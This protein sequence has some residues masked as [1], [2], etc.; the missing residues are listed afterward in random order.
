MYHNS[1]TSKRLLTRLIVLLVILVCSQYILTGVYIGKEMIS[2][3][4]AATETEN[5]QSSEE[6]PNEGEYLRLSNVLTENSIP[7]RRE[8]SAGWGT[9]RV[10]QDTNGNK[11]SVKMEGAYY[12]FD[13]GI[14]AHASSNLYYDISEYSEKYPY[15]TLYMGINQTSSSGN[16]VKVWIYT[17]NNDRFVSSGSQ[18]WTQKNAEADTNRVIMP[19]QNA[20]FEKV[21]IRGAKY[22]RIQAYDNGSNASDHI[23]YINPM[24][25]TE[26]YEE[27]KNDF[28]GV[29]EYDREIK[30]YPNKTL[31]DPK[32]E[33][34]VLQ[35]EFVN[36]VGGY[37]LNRFMTEDPENKMII[38]WLMNDVENL[39][40]YLLGGKPEGNQYLNSFKIL[41]R[42]Y[43][44]RGEDLNDTTEITTNRGKS[45]L[46]KMYKTMMLAISLT[47]CNKVYLW[48]NGG[49]VSDPV[50][51]YDIY[52][53][54]YHGK[55]EANENTTKGIGQ[56]LI[57]KT[58]FASLTVEEMRW[59]MNT[60]IDNEEI[61][62]LNWYAREKKNGA[63]GPY[64]YQAYT[65]GYSY[66]RAKYYDPANYDSW[67]AK[68]N[69][70]SYNITYKAGNPKLWIVFEEGSVCGGLSKTG[71][72]V[73]GSFKG[74]PNTCVSQPGHCAYI[75]YDQ[76]VNGNGIWGLGNDVGGWHQAGRTEHLNVRMPLEWGNQEYIDFNKDW[77]GMATYVLLA[78]GALN[79]YDNYKKSQEILMLADVYKDDFDALYQIYDKSLEALPIN[80]DAWYGKIKAYRRDESKTEADFSKIAKGIFEKLKYYPLPMYHLA[81]EV[82]KELKSPAYIL[83]FTQAQTQALTQAKNATNANTLQL[84]AV[85]QEATH[86]LGQVDT[87]IAKFSFDGENAGAILLGSRFTGSDVAWEYSLDGR[88]TWSNQLYTEAGKH[89]HKLTQKEI[90]TI[91]SE[92]D[93]YVH[94]T[95]VDYSD[96]NVYKIDI[97]ESAGL[98]STVYASDL[99]NRVLDVNLSTEWRYTEND[100]WTKYSEGS[101]D[102]TGDKTVQLRQGATGTRLASKNPV[103][104]TFTKDTDPD[105]RKYIPVSHLTLSAVSTE[106]VNNGGAARYAIDANLNTRWHSAWNG[107][108]TQRYITVK[109]D[110]PVFL[111]AV[112]FVPAGGG[113]GK[114]LD[115][116]VYGSTDGKN[117]TVL[118]SRKNLRYTNMA[119]TIAQAKA[120]TQNFEIEEPQEVQY[121][122]IVAD[123]ASTGHNMARNGNW[124]AARAFNFYQD[125][126]KN[127]HPTA[128]I[129]YSTTEKTNEPV[130]A[131]LIN[132]S[133][134]ITITNN[135]GKD[136]YVFTENGSFTFEF[137][138]E[139]GREGTATAKVDWIDKKGPDADVEYKLG[140]DKKLIAILDNISEDVYLLDK[141]NNKTNYIEVA[142]G[143]VISISF[144]DENGEVYKVSEVDENRVTTKITYKNTT[145]NVD[146]AEYYVITLDNDK[147]LTRTGIDEDGNSITLT[148]SEI[149]ALKSLEEMRSNPLEFYLEKNEEYEFKLLDKASNITVK[150]VKVD[151]IENDTKIIASD[152]TYSTTMLTNKDVTA[153]V[154]P[155][156][157][158]MNG[159]KID[160]KVINE[161][162]AEGSD[163]YTF[164]ENGEFT[165]QYIEASKIDDLAREG[166]AHTAKVNWIDKTAPTAE[167]QYSTTQTT[168]GTVTATLVN[169]SEDITIINNGGKRD[170]TFTQNGEFTFEFQDKAGN[171]GT[172][173]ATVNNISVKGDIN[174]N[175]EVDIDD[176]A[177]L[178][179]HL[180]GIRILE[181]AEMAIADMDG[182]GE[183]TIN[184]LAQMKLE[185]I[186]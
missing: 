91:T 58:K 115:G 173:K 123:N 23:V 11:L 109:L 94:I 1:K 24:L 31:S 149:E 184:D 63:T 48:I 124:F 36:R 25:I 69:L 106:A 12:P 137:E 108:D 146:R 76:D 75:F 128:G 97:Q 156:I 160:A 102:L 41:K 167:I 101:P 7:Y 105:T 81:R 62:W 147:V 68:Y 181:D 4:S 162:G 71:A 57:Q 49:N 122:K 59:V 112:E 33:L 183:P 6:D 170:Y 165:F 117:W 56:D 14:W 17:S 70:A 180:I 67:N 103:T 42:L 143:K 34:L 45:T 64:S 119:D 90:A 159:N 186:K 9:I 134:N 95:G 10:N 185:L 98:P 61:E 169:E 118:A 65:S 130:I 44:E 148:D 125:L 96:E 89:S 92:K 55:V 141:N 19:G 126:T 28:K 78:Q 15:L 79:E 142:N 178:K 82:Q 16:G 155:Y 110:K 83:N 38:D 51:R 13:N 145:G 27:P 85:R 113:N 116:T 161:E 39:G 21:D 175:G 18:N 166:S 54:L 66:G 120:N 157:I 30:A 73:W 84:S 104:F 151:Y 20:I 99:E 153:T 100:D 93:I 22:L 26:N 72:C 8:S 121:V 182:D 163:T 35:R 135:D 80:I 132:P 129:G 111:S 86:L 140:D 53:K 88:E 3:V 114:I 139:Q 168:G 138:D 50:E 164:T 158:D 74:L 107:T 171:K 131:R 40:M 5:T 152:I 2:S 37:A 29:E 47:H 174:G 127:P 154:K 177:K 52:K 43:N 172:A 32:F 46:G 87:Q 144:Y 150:N 77:L 133:T 179:L 60:I 136:S 176:L